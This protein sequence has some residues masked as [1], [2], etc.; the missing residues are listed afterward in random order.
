MIV[1]SQTANM[2]FLNLILLLPSYCGGS[3][4]EEIIQWWNDISISKP[5][6]C[7]MN[8]SYLKPFPTIISEELF[9][10]LQTEQYI[11]SKSCKMTNVPHIFKGEVINGL[12]EGPGK[13][14]LLEKE[15]TDTTKS[16]QTCIETKSNFK[17]VVGN[18]KNG[19]LHGKSV[20]IKFQDNSAIIGSFSNGVP[21]GSFRVWNSENELE[22]KT[23]NFIY[24][25]CFHACFLY[26]AEIY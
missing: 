22:G 15:N 17:E 20:K 9:N 8:G 19:V 25:S 6:K 13:L 23:T 16:N 2:I 1:I 10:D 11:T 24:H 12:F 7:K 5:L 18:F 3:V 4:K 14:R 26:R 21:F